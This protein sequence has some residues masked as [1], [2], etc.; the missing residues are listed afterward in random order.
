MLFYCSVISYSLAGDTKGLK[1]GNTYKLEYG[2]NN[3][4]WGYDV[5]IDDHFRD[6]GDAFKRFRG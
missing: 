4:A 1:H 5:R 6:K 2:S 3:Q